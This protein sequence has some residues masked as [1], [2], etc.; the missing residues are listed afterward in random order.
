MHLCVYGGGGGG[1]A[2]EGY[3]GGRN[4]EMGDVARNAVDRYVLLLWNSGDRN[5]GMRPLTLVA[6]VI[7]SL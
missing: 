3:V 4:I 5:G 6:P 1:F 7:A 2:V